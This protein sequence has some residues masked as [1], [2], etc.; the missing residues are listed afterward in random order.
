M[1]IPGDSAQFFPDTSAN[2]NNE[3]FARKKNNIKNQF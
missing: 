2:L 1:R 3:R